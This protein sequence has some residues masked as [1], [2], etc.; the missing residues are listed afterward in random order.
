MRLRNEIEMLEVNMETLQ[1][2]A[3]EAGHSGAASL[4]RT[5][6]SLKHMR[7]RQ[8]KANRLDTDELAGSKA[9]S[10]SH[11][12]DTESAES[13]G[14]NLKAN[15]GA[16]RVNDSKSSARA[17]RRSR[18][19]MSK[20]SESEKKNIS[21]A[22]LERPSPRSGAQSESRSARSKRNNSQGD[23]VTTEVKKEA[24][25]KGTAKSKI[26][27][28]LAKKKKDDAAGKQHSP[29]FRKSDKDSEATS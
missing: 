29:D 3:A 5:G 16:D 15:R 9:G 24:R 7:S 2:R 28:A 14:R 13:A 11:R 17:K 19:A 22:E 10:I 25:K 21:R 18:S 12:F 27:K 26:L 23:L 6:Q 4:E 1:E 20:A 8:V